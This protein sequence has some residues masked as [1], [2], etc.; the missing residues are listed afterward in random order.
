MIFF[1]EEDDSVCP[2]RVQADNSEIEDDTRTLSIVYQSIVIFLTL[3][4]ALAFAKY[5]LQLLSMSKS[6][7]FFDRLLFY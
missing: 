5:S 1:Q 4:F 2:G 3:L 7:S 6:K